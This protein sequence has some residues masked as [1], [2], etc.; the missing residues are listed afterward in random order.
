MLYVPDPTP[1]AATDRVVAVT[2]TGDTLH[3][4]LTGGEEKG[5]RFRRLLSPD[6]R[7]ASGCKS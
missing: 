4:R 5:T 3:V 1:K 7:Q 6:G 2:L